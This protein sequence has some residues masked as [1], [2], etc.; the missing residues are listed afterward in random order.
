MQILI[1]GN[2]REFDSQRVCIA[3]VVE[4]L[5]LAGKRIAIERNG[6][7]VPRNQFESIQLLDGDKLEI[8]G[9]VGGG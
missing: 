6:E 5:N 4:R 1:N 3:D 8:V 7:I 2:S 9:A